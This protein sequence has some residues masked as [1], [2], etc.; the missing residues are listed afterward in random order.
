MRQAILF[1]RH[2]GSTTTKHAE[3]IRIRRE[4]SYLTVFDTEA[5][6]IDDFPESSPQSWEYANSGPP[7]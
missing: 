1:L 2:Q 7:L 3:L 6:P 5:I 4:R